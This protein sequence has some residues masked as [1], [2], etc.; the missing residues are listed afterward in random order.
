MP[1][2][3]EGDGNGSL[4]FWVSLELRSA[5][6][7]LEKSKGYGK[8]IAAIQNCKNICSEYTLVTQID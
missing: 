5:V 7:E 4:A 8:V 3:I 6:C 1:V 2:A